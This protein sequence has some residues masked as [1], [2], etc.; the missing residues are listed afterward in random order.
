[1]N[2]PRDYLVGIL[3]F[4]QGD[5]FEA[6]EVWEGFWRDTAGPDRDFYQ[7]L[8]QTAVALCHHCNGNPVGADRLLHR[9]SGRLR[10]FEPHFAGLDVTG[11]LNALEAWLQTD[12]R[13][14]GRDTPAPRINLDPPPAEWPETSDVGS[15]P[16][17]A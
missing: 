7:G 10:R 16:H 14:F 17:S 11:F 9:A 15:E 1:M 5:Y 2:Y 3:L 4:N 8:I 12:P 13:S 6:H